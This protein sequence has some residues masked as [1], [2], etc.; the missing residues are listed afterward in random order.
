[1]KDA[2]EPAAG[3][4]T[5]EGMLGAGLGDPCPRTDDTR[6]AHRDEGIVVDRRHDHPSVTAAAAPQLTVSQ[7]GQ[8]PFDGTTDAAAVGEVDGVWCRQSLT[9]RSARNNMHPT[10]GTAPTATTANWAF[11]T[12]RPS[13]RPRNWRHIS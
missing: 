8:K 3:E 5:A 2:E 9:H 10:Y 11:G 7:S 4:R 13:A 1:M 6:V 12:C